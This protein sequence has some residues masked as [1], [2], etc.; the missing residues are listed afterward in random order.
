MLTLAVAFVSIGVVVSVRTVRFGEMVVS[1]EIVPEVPGII[2]VSLA[3]ISGGEVSF[4]TA[5]GAGTTAF[6]ARTTAFGAVLVTF[7][8][9]V[10]LSIFFV[11]ITM[12]SGT[13]AV[14][15]F[16]N[17]LTAISSTINF[18]QINSFTSSQLSALRS[19]LALGKNYVHPGPL[20]GKNSESPYPYQY[21]SLESLSIW[22]SAAES[23]VR[24]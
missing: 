16:C 2:S 17:T 22:Y 23:R 13:S 8:F 14:T 5:F 20:L 7:T 4:T 6:G 3:I 12:I 11:S 24:R 10:N 18:L 15:V 21:S 1:I 19:Y 9:V